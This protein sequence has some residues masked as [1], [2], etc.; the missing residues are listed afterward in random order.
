[1][2]RS[3]VNWLY[4]FIKERFGLHKGLQLT[5]DG[6]CYILLG[7][8][9]EFGSLPLMPTC[10]VLGLHRI[11][12]VV[13]GNFRETVITTK[14]TYGM[15]LSFKIPRKLYGLECQLK[16]LQ[17]LCHCH[18]LWRDK[19]VSWIKFDIKWTCF[20]LFVQNGTH[21]TYFIQCTHNI[22]LQIA[23]LLQ[24]VWLIS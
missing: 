21:L 14:G 4:L 11:F 15:Y 23:G 2:G 8:N 17:L 3:W 16:S 22:L 12:W 19:W 9:G 10:T 5:K 6:G 13:P 7:K 24:H 18:P 1:M 20:C